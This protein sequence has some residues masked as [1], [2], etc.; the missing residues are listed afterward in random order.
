[1]NLISDDPFAGL[2]DDVI[3]KPTPRASKINQTQIGIDLI[4][5]GVTL[6]FLSILCGMNKNT[7]S[8]RLA[9]LAPKHVANNGTKY[10]DVRKALPY[11]VQPSDSSAFFKNLKPKD[12]PLPLK[13]EFWHAADL[14]LKVRQKTGDLWHSDDVHRVFT[15]MARLIRDTVMLWTDTINDSVGLTAVQVNVLD[16]LTRSLLRNLSDVVTQ[17]T[18]TNKTLSYEVDL[19]E[20]L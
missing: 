20:D 15:D 17:Y 14:E 8:S 5:E 12:M 7:I 19:D 16:D 2:D 6:G 10:Y 1:M 9:S 3:S 11:L 18:E 4:N 13:R